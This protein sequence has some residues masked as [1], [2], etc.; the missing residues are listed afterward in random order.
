MSTETQ[1]WS[2]SFH[3]RVRFP[4]ER[5]QSFPGHPSFPDVLTPMHAPIHV[6]QHPNSKEPISKYQ[7]FQTKDVHC[8]V[9]TVNHRPAR[10]LLLVPFGGTPGAQFCRWLEG[11]IHSNCCE[12]HITSRQLDDLA[13]VFRSYLSWVSV[14]WLPA[15]SGALKTESGTGFLII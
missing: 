14:S 9:L 1:N 2:Q 8:Q 3:G 10:A 4:T 12:C 13:L 11:I 15:L 7:K 6:M 5:H